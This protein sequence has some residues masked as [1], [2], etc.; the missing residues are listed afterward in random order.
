MKN[1]NSMKL[2]IIIALV[3]FVA[4]GFTWVISK[5]ST[6]H[7]DMIA[8][9][10]AI[11]RKNTSILNPFNA[12]P[13]IAYLDSFVK[14]TPSS[15][16]DRELLTTKGP[17]LLKAGKEQ[18]AVK[19]YDKIMNEMDFMTTDQV[20]VDAGIAYMRLGERSNC[21]LNHTGSSCIFPIKDDGV[22]IIK[23][24]SGKAIELY[25]TCLKLNPDDLESRWLINIAYMTLGLY[26]RRCCCP[27]LTPLT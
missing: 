10:K 8:I 24:G 20:L 17:L 16:Q 22:H 2:K 4:L 3:V 23:T 18:E 25:K 11:D 15:M 26:R 21:M 9:L 14:A 6:S 7:K 5:Q 1:N 27:G 19:L 13:K 12:E